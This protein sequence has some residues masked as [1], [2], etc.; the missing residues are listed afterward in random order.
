[1]LSNYCSN[2]ANKYG[3]KVGGGNKLIPNLG[4]KSKYTVHYRILQLY[5]S[6]RMKLTKIHSVLKFRQSDWLMKDIDFNTDKRE[7]AANS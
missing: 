1:M 4:N 6:F 7:N 2:I 5:L 3:I